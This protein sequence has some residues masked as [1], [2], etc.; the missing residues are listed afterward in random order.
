MYPILATPFLDD[1]SIDFKSLKPLIDYLIEDQGIDGI[2][3][4]ANASEG[5]LLTDAEKE[6]IAAEVIEIVNGRIPIILSVTHFSAKIAAQK[7]VRAEKDGADCVLTLPPF[8]GKWRSGPKKIKEYLKHIS[9]AVSIPIMLQDHPVSAIALSPA[10]LCEMA[11]EVPG[12]DYLKMEQDISAV[13]VGDIMKSAPD[14]FHGVFTGMA[15]VRLFWEL[16]N[17]AIGCMPACV[18]AKP[19]ADIIHLHWEGKKDESF[20]LFQKWLPLLTFLLRVGRRDLV[21]DYL[22]R[23]GIITSAKLREP[24]ITAWNDWCLGQ[25]EYLLERIEG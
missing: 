3:F 15:G 22:V 9:E 1:E 25:Y 14:T 12:L 23:K 5:H 4:G 19:L 10:V 17:G 7:A 18:P 21:K 2:V 8:F 24:N 16:E 6:R 20:D 13:K 11:A